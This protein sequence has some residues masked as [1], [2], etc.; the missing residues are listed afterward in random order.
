MHERIIG[1]Y[2]E[3]ATAW[4]R[5]RSSSGEL[6]RPWLERFAAELPST[7]SILDMGCGNGH[8][9]ARQLIERGLSVTGVD[10]SPSLIAMARASFPGHEWIVGDMRELDLGRPLRWHHRLAQLFPSAP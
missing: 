4:A 1:L 9:V 5:L 10:S 6:E 2:E 3:H 8:P 7:G